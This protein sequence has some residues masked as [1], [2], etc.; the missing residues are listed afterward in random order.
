[1]PVNYIN[2]TFFQGSVSYKIKGLLGVVRVNLWIAALGMPINL[3]SKNNLCKVAS[4]Y[5]SPEKRILTEFKHSGIHFI[6][7]GDKSAEN[8]N[9]IYA[10]ENYL[11]AYD[12]IMVP[13]DLSLSLSGRAINICEKMNDIKKITKHIDG[14]YGVLKAS[15][16]IFNCVV[17]PLG[18]YKIYYYGDKN[19]RAYVSNHLPFIRE[20][21]GKDE[22]TENVIS[23]IVSGE[24]Y[25]YSTEEKNVFV[26]PES[27]FLQWSAKAGLKVHS[28]QELSKFILPGQNYRTLLSNA[29]DWLKRA[30]NNLSKEYKCFVPLSGGLDSRLVLD[31]YWGN[32]FTN[33]KSYTYPD[34]FYDVSIA[35][36]IAKH[37]GVSHTVLSPSTAPT[38]EYL[39]NMIKEADYLREKNHSRVANELFKERIKEY[40]KNHSNDK[41]VWV[42]G[43]SGNIDRGLKNFGLENLGLNWSSAL[44]NFIDYQYGTDILRSEFLYYLKEKKQNYFQEKFS[45]Y[46]ECIEDKRK[47]GS[48]YFHFELVRMNSSYGAFINSLHYGG[49]FFIPLANV[50]LV[51]A[52]MSGPVE[53][54]SREKTGSVHHQLHKLLTNNETANIPFT[55]GQHW[56]TSKAQRYYFNLQRKLQRHMLDR[57]KLFAKIRNQYLNEN[58]IL[59]AKNIRALS[60]GQYSIYFDK[61][62]LDRLAASLENGDKRIKDNMSIIFRL[63]SLV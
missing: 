26:L 53:L 1:M 15:S 41:R 56:D 27:G 58:N 13:T 50:K 55:T 37:Y 47:L 43:L 57:K 18:S 3:F 14:Q 59:L 12:G 51:Q 30:A 28:L 2:L 9:N 19:N 24:F 32:N 21:K 40:A 25:G 29:A 5:I 22:N 54:L 8:G 38:F 7:I 17:D 33:V 49:N 34:H 48:L 6:S 44:H 4:K 52:I 16:G 31:A 39:T 62:A 42:F 46:L 61:K 45:P 35:K 63:A 20:L 11:C 23:Y 10:T 36:A 60:E